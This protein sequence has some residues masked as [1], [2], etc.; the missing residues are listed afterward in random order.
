MSSLS[1]RGSHGIPQ[2]AAVGRLARVRSA[3]G[4]GT[5]GIG[6][7]YRRREDDATRASVL[8]AVV[9]GTVRIG[10][11]CGRGHGGRGG[12]VR[13]AR[14]V[15]ASTILTVVV[16]AA[17]GVLD[18]IATA[19]GVLNIVA[20]A[21]GV[22]AVVVTGAS[23]LNVV[24]AT[25]GVLAVAVPA[26]AAVTGRVLLEPFVDFSRF[27]RIALPFEDHA[28]AQYESESAHDPDDAE[29]HADAGF[30]CEKPFGG[31]ARCRIGR[32][33]TRGTGGVREEVRSRAAT[34]EAR[35]TPRLVGI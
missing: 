34:T 12:D 29:G 4:G 5:A 15:A 30:V 25:A 31:G 6:E 28:D 17:A 32:Y 23:V 3:G 9:D 35:H 26:A 16:I 19:T 13:R 11:G 22:L 7:V 14:S 10:P 33:G 27:A 18:V 21:A 24:V 8:S 1:L 2:T 20:T